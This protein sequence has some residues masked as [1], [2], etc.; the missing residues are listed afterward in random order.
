MNRLYFSLLITT[1]GLVSGQIGINTAT[2]DPSAILDLSQSYKPGGLKL[3]AVALQSAID[4]TTIPNPAT[5]LMVFTTANAGTGINAVTAGSIY[6]FNGTIWK[7]LSTKDETL[8]GNVPKV[9]AFGKKTTVTGCNGVNTANFALDQIS[10]AALLTSAG[11]FTAPQTG[12]YSFSVYS[13]QYMPA[14][15][16]QAYNTAPFIFAVGLEAFTYKF[17]GS[18]FSDQG[19]ATSGIIYLVQGQ[20]TPPW[21]WTFGTGNT[22]GL[23]GRIKEQSVI[24]EFI[25][26]TL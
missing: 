7:K 3:P 8:T 15:P 12:Y 2:P 24:W 1:F 14:N 18:G 19:A 13:K 22:C 9:V 4:T 16:D 17:R 26:G 23:T 5:G 20:V 11:A 10:N 21:Q 25:G 6:K